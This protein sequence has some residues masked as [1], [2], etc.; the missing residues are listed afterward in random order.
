MG[1]LQLDNSQRFERKYVTESNKSWMFRDMLREKKFTKIYNKRKVISLYFDTVDYK[2]FK[3]NIEGVGLRIKPRLRWYQSLNERDSQISTILE[4]KK[5]KGFVGTKLQFNFGKYDSSEDI[6]EKAKKFEFQNKVSNVIKRQV[7]PVLVTSYDREYYLSYNKKFRSTID[8]NLKVL[9]IKN[10]F[11]KLP[12]SKEI[13]EIKYD[14]KQDQD[15]RNAIINP[16]IRFRFQKFSK[17]VVGLLYLK[18][19]GLI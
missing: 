13:L 14:I 16:K 17:Y 7:F 5:K 19:N 8:T 12:I 3:E 9:S 4:L 11:L 10:F 18:R 2:F 1:K 15:F 6:I